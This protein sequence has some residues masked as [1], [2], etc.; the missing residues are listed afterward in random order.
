MN[1]ERVK[2]L[3]EQL[4]N[5]EAKTKELF[6][7]GK[8]P[9]PADYADIDRIKKELKQAKRKKTLAETR[10]TD[11]LDA[12]IGV[13][14]PR[15]TLDELEGLAAAKSMTLSEYMRWMIEDHLAQARQNK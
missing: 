14:V 3:E 12:A 2:E 1:Q 9:G 8:I 10:E 11:Y 7:A 5:A 15:A 13:K 6:Q 4:S